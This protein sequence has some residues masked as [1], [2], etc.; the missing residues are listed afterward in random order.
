MAFYGASVIHPK[1]IQPLQSKQIP[2]FVRSFVDTNLQGTQVA[3]GASIHP[4]LP[5]FIVKKNQILVSISAK[6]F[7][8]MM[9]EN[10]SEVFQLLHQHLLKVNLIQNSA[11]SFSVCVDNKFNQFDTFHE[12]LEVFLYS[13]GS[14]KMW[15]C[16]HHST[17]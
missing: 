6:D 12:D 13:R 9:E 2:L 3:G 17:F 4:K 8:F 16:I 5:C 11:I 7:S 1:T 14:L 10:I 15:I